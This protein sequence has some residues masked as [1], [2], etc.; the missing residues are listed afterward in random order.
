MEACRDV[1]LTRPSGVAAGLSRNRPAPAPT[2]DT[3]EPGDTGPGSTGP[4]P[5]STPGGTRPAGD[6]RA[7]ASPL[8]MG[9]SSG[10]PTSK[11]RTMNKTYGD[12]Y[13]T[14][15]FGRDPA[16]RSHPARDRGRSTGSGAA[17]PVRR[18]LTR[19]AFGL[20]SLVVMFVSVTGGAS[21]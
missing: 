12:L 5:L 17:L 11:A 2:G 19:T 21:V 14:L 16:R 10:G 1:P 13:T 18:L 20:G 8:S 6:G 9:P 15:T 4:G 3:V 7:G